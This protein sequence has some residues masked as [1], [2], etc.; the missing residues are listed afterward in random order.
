MQISMPPAIPPTKKPI[1]NTADVN[2]WW[3]HKRNTLQH[4]SVIWWKGGN[5]AISLNGWP[6]QHVSLAVHLAAL[7]EH[8]S[9]HRHCYAFEEGTITSRIVTVVTPQ[10]ASPPPPPHRQTLKAPLAG[11]GRITSMLRINQP[12]PL[13]AEAQTASAG[14]GRQ[15]AGRR[16]GFIFYFFSRLNREGDK[17]SR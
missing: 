3:R 15:R 7:G 14:E 5:S 16:A 10:T 1:K 8:I 13:A 11:R 2:C 17:N 9:A 12:L 4:L 6:W